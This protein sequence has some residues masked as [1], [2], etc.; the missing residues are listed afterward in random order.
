MKR[1]DF[2]KYT[3][4]AIATSSL[5]SKAQS[6]ANIN[7]SQSAEIIVVGA[8]VMGGWTAFYLQEQGSQCHLD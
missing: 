5:L 8:G 2:I 4:G 3:S 1:R 7:P 6:F